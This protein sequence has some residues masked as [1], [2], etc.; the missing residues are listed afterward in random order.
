MHCQNCDAKFPVSTDG[1][2]FSTV[3]LRSA[4]QWNEDLGTNIIDWDGFKDR[5]PS[6]M[7]TREEFLKRS[8]HATRMVSKREFSLA[9]LSGIEEL[10][11]EDIARR[12]MHGLAKYGVTVAD[13][14]LDEI[15][16]LQHSYEELLDAAIYT[17]RLIVLKSKRLQSSASSDIR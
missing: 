9:T 12:Q 13:N 14:D 8:I 15:A 3:D 4:A 2:I 16:W 1:A 17:K 11:C 6:G 7:M 10:V 5:D